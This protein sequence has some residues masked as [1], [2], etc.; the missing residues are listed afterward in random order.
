MKGAGSDVN[1]FDNLLNDWKHWILPSKKARA[2]P[3]IC[4]NLFIA[5]NVFIHTLDVGTRREMRPLRY[6][7]H[8]RAKMDVSIFPMLEDVNN[9]MEEV[10]IN[11]SQSAFF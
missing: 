1:L 6:S 11:T 8:T 10:V 3:Q 2:A 5:Q 9:C 7:N 4:Y